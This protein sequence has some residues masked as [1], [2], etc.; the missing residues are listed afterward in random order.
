[1]KQI[2]STY[3][4]RV[5]IV[6]TTWLLLFVSACTQQ[7]PVLP[8]DSGV[9][10]QV[11]TSTRNDA[12]SAALGENL[13][14]CLIFWRED[15]YRNT[16]MQSSSW[17]PPYLAITPDE[18]IDYYRVDN[19]VPFNTKNSYPA[20]GTLH[21]MG[22]APAELSSSDNYRTLVIPSSLQDGKT[23][24]LSGDGNYLRIGSAERPF[25][26]KAEN[27]TDDD[28]KDRELDFCHLTSKIVIQAER[29][30]STYQRYTVRNIQ[31]KVK[32]QR[33]P[34]RL[35][36]RV[37]DAVSLC[38]GYFPTAPTEPQEITLNGSSEHLLYGAV[39][40]LDSCYVYPTGELSHFHGDSSSETPGT[41]N[42]D[43]DISAEVLPF[44]EGIGF[45]DE[46]PIPR[47]WLGQQVT[48][49]TKTGNELRMGYKYVITLT[50][51]IYGILLQAVE[52]DW[53][54]GGLHF[55]PITPVS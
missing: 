24:F 16:I 7:E 26:V 4:G 46:N 36:W 22:F 47:E 17:A 19:H 55:I 9:P 28:L 37:I 6:A 5:R 18:E 15:Y 38:G 3:G 29:H 25:E 10:I 44:V 30:E 27:E 1:M 21:V 2:Y 33:V 49:T 39:Q 11:Y 41:Y 51:D 31:V 23:D 12:A 45:D 53:E 35:E 54:D 32:N 48:I 43:L 50:F 34:T 20:G 40:A 52:M 13:R 42:L 14:S 8:G